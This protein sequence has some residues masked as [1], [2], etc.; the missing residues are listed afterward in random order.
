MQELNHEHE[1]V[2]RIFSTVRGISPPGEGSSSESEEEESRSG[3]GTR[4]GPLSAISSV[5]ETA[6]ELEGTASV[7]D[8][9]T[10]VR[11]S[12]DLV[13]G[14]ETFGIVETCKI[15]STAL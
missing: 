13:F 7:V 9:Q 3:P 6:I 8:P 4:P 10:L 12:R 2:S 1:E 14:L 5:S 15:L 11:S